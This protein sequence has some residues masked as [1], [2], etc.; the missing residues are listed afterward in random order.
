MGVVQQSMAGLKMDLGEGNPPV[1]QLLQQLLEGLNLPLDIGAVGGGGAV[2]CAEVGEN[3]LDPKVLHG[4]DLNDLLQVMAGLTQAV[5][6]G[7]NGQVDRQGF[8]GLAEL[9][10]VG[11]IHCGLGEFVPAQQGDLAGGGIPQD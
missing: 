8:A 10:G 2:R 9:H 1:F 4:E 11:E 3:P 7:V 6:P 5:H